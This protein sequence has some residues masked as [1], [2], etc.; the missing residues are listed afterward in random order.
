MDQKITPNI[1][2]VHQ[3][4]ANTNKSEITWGKDTPSILGVMDQK[5]TSTLDNPE[6]E[7]PDLEVHTALQSL[8][9]D[10]PDGKVKL[11]CNAIIAN[12]SRCTFQTAKLKKSKAKQR[13]DSH[14]KGA[15]HI[16]VPDGEV[17]IGRTL[18]SVTQEE[19]PT[20]LQSLDEGVPDGEDQ[21]QDG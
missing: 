14:I 10:L 9:K 21:I 19:L 2:N 7:T 20:D 1:D 17:P 16:E 5:I 11:S 12:G 15:A 18:H 8:D 13:L 4:K 3:R 6:V